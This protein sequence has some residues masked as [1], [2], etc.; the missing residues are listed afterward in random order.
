M[1]NDMTLI[2]SFYFTIPSSTRIS[3]WCSMA[4]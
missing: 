2:R 1:I 4:S 3:A